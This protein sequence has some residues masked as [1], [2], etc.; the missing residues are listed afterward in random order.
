MKITGLQRKMCVAARAEIVF[1][2]F[3]VLTLGTGS[4]QNLSFGDRETRPVPE[5]L[6]S[7]SIYELWLT[8]FSK[9]GNLRGA[10]PEL[11]RVADLGATIIYLGPIAKYSASPDASPY[12]IADYNA[13][14][15]SAGTRAGSARLYCRRAQ[16]RHLKVML[17]IVYYHTAPDNIMMKDNPAFFVKTP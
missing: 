10:I 13:I 12:N 5:W 4:A 2:I 1:A 9:E 3:L 6:N 16:A 7:S 15:P 17:D 14:D 11:P 8:A